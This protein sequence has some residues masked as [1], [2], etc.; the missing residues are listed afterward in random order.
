M[1]TALSLRLD[2]T[3]GEEGSQYN[4]VIAGRFFSVKVAL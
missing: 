2:H 4:Q 1:G 3:V